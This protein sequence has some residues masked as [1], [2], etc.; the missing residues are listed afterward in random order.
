MAEKEDD[1][2]FS[3]DEMIKWIVPLLSLGVSFEKAIDL[4]FSAYPKIV[5]P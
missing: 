4:V 5:P 3:E 2:Y 1:C